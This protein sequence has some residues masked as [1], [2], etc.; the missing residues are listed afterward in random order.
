MIDTTNLLAG[1][2][3]LGVLAAFWSRLKMLAARV[4]SLVVVQV[5]VEGW[6]GAAVT[7]YCWKHFRRS[8]Y[9]ARRYGAFKDYVR[10]VGRQQC[11]MFETVGKSPLVFWAGFYPM[12]LQYETAPASSG[13]S[14]S[15]EVP[16]VMTFLRGTFDLDAF[17]VKA[18]SEYNAMLHAGDGSNSRFYVHKCIGHRGKDKQKRQQGGASG[19]AEA[20]G[21]MAPERRVIG[22]DLS[23]IGVPRDSGDPLETLYINPEV[24]YVVDSGR[25]WLKSE[26]W[27]KA[28]KIPWRM[29]WL[30]YG[31][32]GTGKS[33]LVRAVGQVL[34]LPVFVLDLATYDNA[35]F[36]ETWTSLQQSSPCIMLL[37]DI[38]NVFQGRENVTRSDQDEGLT[39]DCLLNCISGAGDA[40]GLLCIVTTNRPELLD[41]A[42][43]KPDP[44][45][46]GV[47]TRPGRIDRAVEM[48]YLNEE[49][50]RHIAKRIL[51][52]CPERIE[53][54]VAST[55]GYSGAQ[56]EDVCTRIALEHYWKQ[57]D[58]ADKGNVPCETSG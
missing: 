20:S 58:N 30:L 33:S 3:V 56:V 26:T 48:T 57:H 36:V 44:N 41:E 9:G 51:D 14:L 39:F 19:L 29:G 43:G 37:E 13:P 2:F 8:P 5:N 21:A 49:G 22:W 38:D 7:Y 50:R 11:I 16:L 1:G 28:H 32:P 40:S 35:G 45:K 12:I 27:Y 53:E 23:D 52:G 31:P 18:V 34:D 47:S 55:V 24:R 42:L 6:S 17:L 15:H 46:P 25:R 10:P 4:M 54:V